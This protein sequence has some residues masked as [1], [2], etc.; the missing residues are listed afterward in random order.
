MA[1]LEV[2]H[3]HGRVERVSVARDQTILIGSSPKCDIILSGTGVLP[4]HGR[5]R[6][7]VNRFKADASPDAQY[8]VINGHKMA[9]SSFHQGDEIEIGPNR[10]FMIQVEEDLP[11]DEP[12]RVQSPPIAARSRPREDAPPL[13]AAPDDRRGVEQP[14][15]LGRLRPWK[16]TAGGNEVEA[17]PR[18][19][20]AAAAPARAVAGTEAPPGESPIRA[21]G[22][23]VAR[24]LTTGDRPPGQERI[25]S[26]PLVLALAVALVVL[27]L[28]GISLR[29][30]IARTV[31]TRQY[32]RAVES[33]DSGDD[34]NAIRQFDEF[35][36]ANPKD[37]RVEKA[38]VLRAL[39]NVRQFAS[40]SGG[41]WSNALEAEQAMVKSVGKLTPFR[42][43]SVELAELII[44]TGEALAD[45]AKV[46]ADP[47]SLAEAEATVAL[48]ARVAGASAVAFLKRSRLPS[49]L[50][51]ARAAVRK[52]V[53][54]AKALAEMDKGLQAKSSSRVY[55]ARDALVRTYADLAEDRALVERLTRANDLIRSAVSIDTTTR[56]AET[57][58]LAEPFG[59][60]VSLVLRMAP[61]PE[62]PAASSSPSPNVPVVFAR[63]DGIAYGLDGNTGA[64][65]WQIAVGLSAPFGPL[66]IAGGTTALCFDARHD[67]LV[68]V[69][70][71]T[72][73]LLWR[74][75]I[76][77]PVA[78][79]PL[80]LGNSVIQT[81]P[82]GKL[83]VISLN[84]GAV[85]ATANLGLPLGLVP[86]S[87]EAGQYLYVLADKDCLFVLA[88][89]PL[90]CVRVEYLGHAAGSVAASPA[91][92][93]RF[94]VLA[95][96]HAIDSGRW[97]IFVIGEDGQTLRQVQQWAVPGWTWGTPTSSGSVIWSTGDRGSVT[98]LAM[99]D[100]TGKDPFRPI[101]RTNPEANPTGPAFALA[102]SERELWIASGRSGRYELNT[103]RGTLSA[104]WT[105]KEAGPA[106]APPRV[107]GGLVV[108]TQENTEGPGVALWGVDPTS[109]QTR[110]RT[111]LGSPWPVPLESIG[112]GERLESIGPDGKTLEITRERLRSGGFIE[113]T[114]P[115]PGGF[116]LPAGALR[117]LDGAGMTVLAPPAGSNHLWARAGSGAGAFRKLE[118]PAPLGAAPLFWGREL[119]VPG[120]DGR[121][122]LIDPATGE[123]RAEPFVPPFDRAHPVRWR[124]PVKL[125][126]DAV[127]VAD[128]SGRVR[129]LTRVNEPRPRLQVTAEANLGAELLAEAVSTGDTIVLLTADGRVRALAARD[130]SPAG[131]WPLDTPPAL[132]PVAIDG[133]VFLAD[134]NGAV[135]A[136]GPDGQRLW[137][138][139]LRDGAPAGAPVVHGDSAWFLSGTGVLQRQAMAD[140][141]PL[142]RVELGFPPAGGLRRFGSDL[143]LPAGLAAVRALTADGGLIPSK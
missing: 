98:A 81:T 16:S 23:R 38:R 89:D 5:L 95:E 32:H 75:S 34:R 9:A 128:E 106:L 118:L 68:R 73:K 96:N 103:E 71:R 121:L 6:W 50:A 44:K 88:R 97:R 66:A 12:T 110:W 27:V 18:S 56:P 72:G 123:S 104:A 117:R 42:D 1:T 70:A 61:A 129:R 52:A 43:A 28:L 127:A 143:I 93:G 82:S 63:A 65:L 22:G 119:L 74:Q 85:T 126:G 131:V 2:H 141:A 31:A 8:L 19:L 77:E 94:L 13:R 24:L 138:I 54:R 122:S 102:R 10:I 140:G 113:A 108:L 39:A 60:L 64:P 83:L 135:L 47:K 86:V 132:P 11:S 7:K 101:A 111:V 76:G 125:E 136:L 48:H 17:A 139:V 14:E 84:S 87:D 78:G 100:Y 30:V 120:G 114:L 112:I 45:R 142:D 4:F 133:R 130:L 67:E 137:S 109:G 49:K 91:R 26:S 134:R 59:P 107:A 37:Q 46:S 92:Q 57:S 115:R 55:A 40:P 62:S 29:D 41:S 25:L 36:T 21:F 105:L 90:G 116:R 51:D 99:G 79:P 15:L 58:A 80:V 35:L 3:G 20:K 69:E 124:T 33:L 53:V